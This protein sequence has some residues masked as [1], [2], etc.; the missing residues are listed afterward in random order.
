MRLSSARNTVMRPSSTGTFGPQKGS[1]SRAV[2]TPGRCGGTLMGG[3][4]VAPFRRTQAMRSVRAMVA[5]Q[6]RRE[7]GTAWGWPEL[8]RAAA[9]VDLLVVLAVG[10]GLRDREAIAFA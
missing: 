10:V 1:G 2:A 9:T 8:L 4:G 6:E 7:V 3:F 5:V